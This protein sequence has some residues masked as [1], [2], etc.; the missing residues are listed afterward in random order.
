MT[1]LS[2]RWKN[3]RRMAWIAFLTAITY[4]LGVKYL[5]LSEAL[6]APVF[7]FSGT[8]VSVYIGGAVADDFLQK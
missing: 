1:V 5:G 2:D 4:P 7:A 3:R 8:I 6:A